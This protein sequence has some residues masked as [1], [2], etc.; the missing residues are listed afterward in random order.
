M[1]FLEVVFVCAFVGAP[2]CRPVFAQKTTTPKTYFSRDSCTPRPEAS[3]IGER[4]TCTFTIAVDIDPTRIPSEL[5]VIKCNCPDSLCSST[6][7][8]RCKEVTNTIP[9][10]YI[11]GSAGSKMTN[12]TIELTT[13]CVCAASRSASANDGGI[14]RTQDVD[15]PPG[16]IS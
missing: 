6:G 4:S 12:G 9:V 11:Q 15:P 10:A 2:V 7:D 16:G 13:C 14:P 5:P 8:Y 3:S 1:H